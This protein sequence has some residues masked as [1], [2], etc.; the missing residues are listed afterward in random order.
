MDDQRRI[1]EVLFARVADVATV[2]IIRYLGH[3][4]MTQTEPVE[5]GYRARA[6]VVRSDVPNDPAR[7]AGSAVARSELQAVREAQTQARLAIDISL[8]DEA[9][10]NEGA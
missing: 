4:I 1:E 7:D 3:H 2:E 5:T 9:L 10:R 6:W 8:E